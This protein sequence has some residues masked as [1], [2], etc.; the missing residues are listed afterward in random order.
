MS[1]I[2]SDSAINT[3]TN[4]SNP[5]DDPLYLSNSYFP[6]VQLLNTV[7]NGRN[8]LSWSR[9]LIMALGSKNKQG[10]LDGTTAM[11][12]ATSPKLQQWRRL[13][14]MVRC[15]IL[16]SMSDELKEGFMTVKTA[17]A[18]WS[19]IYESCGVMEK[20]TCNLIKKWLEQ[21]S[22]EKVI[23]FLMGLNE[24]YDNLR[25]NILSMEPMPNINKAY[26][27]V[28]QIESQKRISNIIN[29]SQDA[30]AFA[31]EKRA[32]TGY[33]RKDL[34]K[35]RV[36]E[37]WCDY[38][39][40]TGHV[41]DRCIRLH[42]ELRN[43]FDNAR[44]GNHRISANNVESQDSIREDHPL[45]VASMPAQTQQN[46]YVVDSALVN[47]VCKQMMQANP[48]SLANFTDAH[49]NFAGKLLASNAISTNMYE[50]AME[51]I[52]DSG[53]TDHMSSYKDHSIHVTNLITPVLAGLP[54]G[55][56]KTV[57]QTGH[58]QIHPK[59]ILY[60][61]LL[62][63][64]FKHNL[65]SISKLL[66]KNGLLIHFDMDKCLI[67]D[68]VR[69]AV[70][71]GLR[72]G[73]LY[74]LTRDDVQFSLRQHHTSVQNNV[75]IASVHPSIN[76]STANKK[77]LDIIHAR[78]GH[79]SLSKMQ[80]KSVPG[81]PHQNG[82][83]ERKHRHLVETARAI[84]LFA[85]LPKKFWED[86][87]LSA[88]HIINKLPTPLLGWK[89]PYELLHKKP[90]TYEELR[91]MGC[92]C[93]APVTHKH[94]DKFQARGRK[95]IGDTQ[96]WVSKLQFISLLFQLYSKDKQGRTHRERII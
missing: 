28:Q 82:R 49:I 53:A 21:A 85:G 47:A 70:A 26:S 1:E 93:Y 41:K 20:C 13:D 69:Q 45:D 74:K 31:A 68:P 43:K 44:F 39:K 81:V 27:F 65:L 56:T 84:M 5:Y 36:D 61:V 92:L 7:F 22:K 25:S 91:I 37:R 38:C 18:L 16:N 35:P 59:I 42:P 14:T 19:D 6:G 24:S 30:S 55:S 94:R 64:D 83:V 77:Q 71:V 76:M 78:L 90:P 96:S 89:T 23:T 79:T 72:Q 67:Q 87:L 29:L 17:K 10:F 2:N 86:C 80:H 48:D 63:P 3:D 50:N 54:D 11:P 12:A 51:W 75:S 66:T 58:V 34:K 40:R 8:Y 52:I 95:C 62:V 15:W 32:G 60:D 33:W 46:A 57:T 9:S 4:Y 88:I 73:G